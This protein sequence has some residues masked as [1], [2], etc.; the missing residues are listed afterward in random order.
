MRVPKEGETFAIV[1]VHE[2]VI[3]KVIGV[4]QTKRVATI[5]DQYGKRYLVRQRKTGNSFY[6]VLMEIDNA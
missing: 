5:E 4:D 2:R 1:E 6:E 3:V